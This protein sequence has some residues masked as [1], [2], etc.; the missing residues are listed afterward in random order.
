MKC[1]K[2]NYEWDF[3]PIKRPNPRDTAC[4]NCK[5]MCILRENKLD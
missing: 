1:D 4:P 2:C 3:K 5:N